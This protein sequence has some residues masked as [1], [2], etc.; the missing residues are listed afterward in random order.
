DMLSAVT[1]YVEKTPPHL[2][3]GEL[4]MPDGSKIEA[5]VPYAP[6]EQGNGTRVYVD[7]ALVGVVKRKKL[8]ND[9]A[10]PAAGDTTKFSLGQYVGKLGA[11]PKAVKGIDLIA[12]DDV[13]AHV[14]PSAAKETAFHVPPR[15]QGQIL[16]DVP[17]QGSDGNKRA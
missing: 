7:G 16:V 14:A 10:L 8:T 6:A 12:G 3:D 4:V 1:V 17:T 5:K 15:N 13:V 11:D 9:I 2:Q